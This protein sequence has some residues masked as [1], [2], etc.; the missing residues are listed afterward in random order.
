MLL[1]SQRGS[2]RGYEEVL[3]VVQLYRGGGQP[4]VARDLYRTLLTKGNSGVTN[5]GGVVLVVLH[6]RCYNW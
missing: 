4:V 2:T 1:V 5:M 6:I 3:V